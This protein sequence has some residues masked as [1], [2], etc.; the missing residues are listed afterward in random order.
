MITYTLSDMFVKNKLNTIFI[1]FVQNNS[2]ILKDECK[3]IHFITFGIPNNCSWKGSYSDSQSPFFSWHDIMNIYQLYESNLNCTCRL[4]F[5]NIILNPNNLYYDTTAENLLEI[6]SL[7]GSPQIC[8]TNNEMKIY[9]SEKYPNLIRFVGSEAMIFE[10]FQNNKN[11]YK[12]LVRNEFSLNQDDLSGISKNQIEIIPI[13]P[14]LSHC[15][16]EQWLN[17][18]K[19]NQINLVNFSRDSNFLNCNHIKSSILLESSLSEFINDGYQHFHSF[20]W[21]TELQQL[22]NYVFDLIKPEYQHSTIQNI[23]LQL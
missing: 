9:L 5:S 1:N 15:S 11:E 13:Y 22:Y 16:Y 23:M 18:M 20:S 21:P 12:T 14:C 8:I 17:C 4:D 19:S 2:Y 7:N 3:D 6:A 10:D